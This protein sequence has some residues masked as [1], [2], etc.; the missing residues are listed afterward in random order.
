VP[1]VVVPCEGWSAGWLADRERLASEKVEVDIKVSG[2]GVS[3]REP[4]NDWWDAVVGCELEP[5]RLR[6]EEL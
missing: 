5:E 4:D 2:M 6:F 3:V 1:P